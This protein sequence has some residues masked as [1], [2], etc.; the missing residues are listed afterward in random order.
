MWW[1][2]YSSYIILVVP[3]I[4]LSMVA[5]MLVRSRFDKYSQIRA[6]SGYT[7]LEAARRI[8]SQQGLSHIR[9]E[10]VPGSLTDHY[11]PKEQVLRLSDATIDSSSI[12]AIGVAIHEV[13]HAV[14]DKENYWPNTVRAALVLPAN[15]GS[16]FGP[17][18]AIA[19]LLIQSQTG[20]I[21][22]RMG[23]IAFA[24]GVLFYLITLPVEFNASRRALVM[25]DEAGL[26]AP[27]E[28][29]GAKKVLSAAALTYVAS[30]LTAFMSLVR[31][32][33]MARSRDRD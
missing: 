15:I 7:G 25:I 19:G 11:S 26:L 1:E 27:D 30:A 23:I 6:R 18:L 4:L 31:L 29:K 13:G 28:R 12:A 22:L 33:L 16:R 9:V 17:Y 32:I 20:N 8:L 21:L 10:H 5:Q 24:A 3:F 2:Y 14:Q